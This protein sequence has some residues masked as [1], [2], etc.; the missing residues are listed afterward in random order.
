VSWPTG[1][2]SIEAVAENREVFRQLD[3]AVTDPDAV[4]ATNTS[5]IPVV[6]LAVVTGRR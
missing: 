3:K 5:S 1:S 2:S 6:D 4:L